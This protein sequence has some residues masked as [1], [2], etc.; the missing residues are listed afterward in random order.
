MK[1]K[2]SKI[3]VS[4]LRR[5]KADWTLQKEMINERQ[6]ASMDIQMMHRYKNKKR[7]VIS[8]ALPW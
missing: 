8:R 6:D 3:K 4:H 2:I 7:E 1:N 5:L